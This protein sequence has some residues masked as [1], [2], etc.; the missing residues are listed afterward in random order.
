M[1]KKMLLVICVGLCVPSTAMA[2][3]GVGLKGGSSPNKSDDLKNELNYWSNGTLE[4]KGAFGGLELFIEGNDV[5]R[6]GLSVGFNSMSKSKLDEYR[7]TTH[8]KWEAGATSVP[9][10]IYWKHKAED[11]SFSV[12]LGAGA[13]I[14][15]AKTTV[16]EDYSSNMKFSQTK[17]VP[18]VDAGVEWY[19]SKRVSLGCNLAYLFNAKFDELKDDN[20][21]QL[22]TRPLSNGSPI[23]VNSTQPSGWNKYNQDYGG[24]RGDLSLRVY[25]GGN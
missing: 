23:Y 20:G 18:H 9:I 24:L 6:W 3:W 21:D 2:Y 7:L 11:S 22:Y 16:I 4:K 19:L 12:R 5:N 14:M 10:T 17:A 25:F 8:E 13:D 1:I 15:T